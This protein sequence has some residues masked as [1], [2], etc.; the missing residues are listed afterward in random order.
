MIHG[1]DTDHLQFHNGAT[2]FVKH[3]LCLCKEAK[4]AFGVFPIMEQHMWGFFSSRNAFAILLSVEGFYVTMFKLYTCCHLWKLFGGKV[5][6]EFPKEKKVHV[7]ALVQEYFCEV[8]L[9]CCRLYSIVFISFF[10]V[11]SPQSKV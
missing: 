7:S 11:L 8:S 5:E 3:N 9:L 1:F 2:E 6:G 10:A 4:T